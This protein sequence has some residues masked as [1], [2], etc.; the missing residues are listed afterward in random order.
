MFVT[1]N[2]EF[3]LENDWNS[4]NF[5]DTLIE[6]LFGKTSIK[7]FNFPKQKERKKKN[8]NLKCC[9][10]V[11][12]SQNDDHSK[13]DNNT[14]AY[15]VVSM[16]NTPTVSKS[17]VTNN[18]D[19]VTV[20]K[21]LE[22]KRQTVETDGMC[23]ERTRASEGSQV[24][25]KKR[26]PN[27][28]NKYKHLINKKSDAHTSSDLNVFQNSIERTN[29]E[30][31]S[32]NEDGNNNVVGFSS[33][34][35]RK[36]QMSNDTRQN[37][38]RKLLVHSSKSNNTELKYVN[39]LK[40]SKKF[41]YG[42][43]YNINTEG[44][45]TFNDKYISSSDHQDKSLYNDV[46]SDKL[47]YKHMPNRSNSDAQRGNEK[48]YTLMKSKKKKNIPNSGFKDKN[49]DSHLEPHRVSLTHKQNLCSETSEDLNKQQEGYFNQSKH[50]CNVKKNK[51][52]SVIREKALNRLNAARFR[53][54]NEKLYTSTSKEAL[55]MFHNDPDSFKLYHKGYKIQVSKW[56]INPVNIIIQDI[57]K[58][59]LNAVIADF[60]CGEAKIAQT[61][62]NRRVYSFDLLAVNEYVTACDI[63]KVPLHNDCIDI[64][65][66]C[67]SLMGTNLQDYLAEANRV[68]KKGGLLKIAEIE[69]R[70]TK[71]EN[72]INILK[73]IGFSLLSKEQSQKM[74]V[75]FDFKK[76]KGIGNRQKLP[77]IQLQPCLYKKR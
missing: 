63:A 12:E 3:D 35:C 8:T 4:D 47:S 50:P 6:K 72:F 15:D 45:N 44:E 61:F 68:L 42:M 25:K 71:I 48:D 37:R 51:S 16:Y 56:P 46:Y 32:M 67:L 29:T 14:T 66:F 59:P 20:C 11:R 24:H 1:L 18:V 21:S 43:S 49:K 69:S 10:A 53:Y 58:V 60:G 40:N 73:K 65:V 52:S 26:R 55:Q 39:S 76:T 17:C 77:S 64:A 7:N 27:K 62:V 13:T 33:D 34:C 41:K 36:T 75:F 9:L 2:M 28:R 54:L 70:F 30:I 22:G 74:F 31:A 19:S 38:K 23:T 57:E 5:T